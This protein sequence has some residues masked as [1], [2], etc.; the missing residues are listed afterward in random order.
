MPL[1]FIIELT[2]KSSGKIKGS[3]QMYGQNDVIL[4][5]S[6]EYRV[7]VSSD[8]PE[9]GGT[10]MRFHDPLTICKE[11][12]KSSPALY[13]HLTEGDLLSEVIIRFYKSDPWGKEVNYHTIV[14][15][16]AI[17]TDI[18]PEMKLAFLKENEPYR[19]MEYVSFSYRSI[20]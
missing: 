18:S 19:H 4:A 8:Q 3:S 20:R 11:I 10:G 6:F 15:E 17:V 14:L 5:Y 1:P 2:S 13:Q 12:D 7:H 9:D 16:D